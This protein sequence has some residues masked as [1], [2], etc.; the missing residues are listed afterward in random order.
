MSDLLIFPGQGQ[1]KRQCHHDD[2]E[3]DV[4][5]DPRAHAFPKTCVGWDPN[6]DGRCGGRSTAQRSAAVRAVWFRCIDLG[7]TII[8]EHRD[9]PYRRTVSLAL[10]YEFTCLYKTS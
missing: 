3:C 5:E 8:A 7:A 10:F 4:V 9:L 2:D 1:G 6:I